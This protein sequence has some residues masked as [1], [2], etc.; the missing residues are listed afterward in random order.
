[1]EAKLSWINEYLERNGY[2]G[3]QW[4]LIYGWYDYRD[5][6]PNERK[7]KWDPLRNKPIEKILSE[8]K[9]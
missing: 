2:K 8:L 4:K 1:L 6:D 3:R 7:R 5:F 9:E